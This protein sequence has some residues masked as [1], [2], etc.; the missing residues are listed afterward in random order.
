LRYLD[1][2]GEEV[3]RTE[4]FTYAHAASMEPA[5]GR[6]FRRVGRGDWN[7]SQIEIS[8]YLALD[9][10][11]RRHKVPFIWTVDE[12]RRL[13]RVA[14]THELTEMCRERLGSWLV[15]RELAGID[16][17]HALRA[18]E[19]ARREVESRAEEAAR[20]AARAHEEE[21]VRVREDSGQEALERLVNVLMDIEAAPGTV[22]PPAAAVAPETAAET[23]EP[24][25]EA[26][27][28]EAPEAVEE[29]EEAVSFDEP[30]ID[31][32][33]C[34]TCNECTNLNPR[35]FQYNENKQ[36]VIGDP[37]AGTFEEL[38]KAAE[39]CPARCIHPGKPRKDDPTVTD[40]LRARAAK[41]D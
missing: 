14:L 11:G 27:P 36:A 26:A 25:T 6:H 15:L 5:Y 22:P 7:D 34:T 1:E 23:A 13:A 18:A 21:I 20:E 38:V 28:A 4:G 35:L 37:S 19:E 10:A 24:A 17:E 41:F 2:N 29:E 8:E 32:A 39:K 16:N 30:Y 3:T 40:A 33:L 9:D 31:S 12:E